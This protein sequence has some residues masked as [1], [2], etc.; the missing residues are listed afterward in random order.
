MA[1]ILS[2]GGQPDPN[3]WDHY[4]K[5]WLQGR[6]DWNDQVKGRFL[7]KFQT[8]TGSSTMLRKNW[9]PFHQTG[10][11]ESCGNQKVSYMSIGR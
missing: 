11:L 6:E 10:P 3:Q 4:D 7:K 8:V 5:K 1:E 2:L 9:I